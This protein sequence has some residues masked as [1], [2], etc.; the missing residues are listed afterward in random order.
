MLNRTMR[1]I[2]FSGLC[3]CAMTSAWA[4]GVSPYLPLELM[5]EIERDIERVLILADKPIL[6][7]PIPAAVVL[8]ALPAACRADGDASLCRRVRRHLDRYMRTLGLDHASVEA[9]AVDGS[10]PLPNARGMASESTWRAS[11]LAHWQPSDHLLVSVGGVA[12]DGDAVP[13]GSVLSTGFQYAQLDIGFRRA[14][15]LAVHAQ[16]HADQYTGQDA[17]IRNLVEL[18]PH[19]P[20]RPEL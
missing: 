8:E 18:L 5:P 6:A 4:K 10:I 12:Y 14:L 3:A 11:G 7:R 15:A 1:H 19:L 9:A 13:S 20:A 2:V 16:R 17:A